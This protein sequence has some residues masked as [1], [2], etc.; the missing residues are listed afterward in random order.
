M[1]ADNSN[2]DTSELQS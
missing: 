2:Y 1:L